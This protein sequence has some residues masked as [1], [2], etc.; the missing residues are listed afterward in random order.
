M[1]MLE[2]ST[3]ASWLRSLSTEPMKPKWRLILLWASWL[4]PE[5]KKVFYGHWLESSSHSVVLPMSVS[6]IKKGLG[7]GLRR[8]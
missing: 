6:R 2:A 5:G 1:V 8:T 3:K 4:C 7:K